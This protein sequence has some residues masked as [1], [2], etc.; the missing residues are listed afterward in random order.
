MNES[1]KTSIHFMREK[2]VGIKKI[3][4]E[5]NIGVGTVYKAIEAQDEGTN[6]HIH[7]CWVLCLSCSCDG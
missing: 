2:G 6:S 1:L 4:K 3:T 7:Y 5:L